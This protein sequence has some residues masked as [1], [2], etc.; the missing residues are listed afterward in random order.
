MNGTHVTDPSGR[1]RMEQLEPRILLDAAVEQQAVELFGG[2]PAAG[3]PDGSP[4]LGDLSVVFQEYVPPAGPAGPSPALYPQAVPASSFSETNS[5][6]LRSPDADSTTQQ[7]IVTFPDPQLEAA[8]REA[9]NKPSGD[10]YSSELE[11]IVDLDA[12]IR[13]I[14]DLDGLEYCSN[15]ERLDL[16]WNRIISISPLRDLYSLRDL[17]LNQNYGSS[18]DQ[19]PQFRLRTGP[20]PTRR[21]CRLVACVRQ[22]IRCMSYGFRRPAKAN[23]KAVAANVARR[24]ANS[25][26]EARAPSP[27]LGTS[28]GSWPKCTRG[29]RG[30][31]L[32]GHSYLR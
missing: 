20:Q 12:S 31:K 6:A 7:Q 17:C 16:S 15:L 30:R 22:G 27:G 3:V 19:L 18:P 25:Q 2:S 28:S 11:G 5:A 4:G 21:A 23:A 13:W 32:I 1:P 10:I 29:F 26:T 8:I 9:I 14:Q 24:G